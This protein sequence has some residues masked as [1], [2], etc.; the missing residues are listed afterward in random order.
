M[1]L[2]EIINRA[3]IARDDNPEESMVGWAYST[4]K[5][6]DAKQIG[7]LKSNLDTEVYK[8]PDHLKIFVMNGGKP[9]VYLALA[10]FKDGFKV[11]VVNAELEVKGKGLAIQLYKAVT[12]STNKPIYSDSTQTAASKHAIWNKLIQQFPNKVVA[13]D[14]RTGEDLPITMTKQG[15]AINGNQPIYTDPKRNTAGVKAPT[16]AQTQRTRLLKLLP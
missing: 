1:K 12:S 7:S 14:Q 13:Y 4:A 8:F 6:K 2:H 5:Q 3:D 15:P 16:D 10:T 11:N 9:V